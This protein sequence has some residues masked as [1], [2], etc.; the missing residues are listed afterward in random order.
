MRKILRV[1]LL[2]SVVSAFCVS[3][4]YAQSAGSLKTGKSNEGEYVIP[5]TLAYECNVAVSDSN[6]SFELEECFKRLIRDRE[7]DGDKALKAAEVWKA[8]LNESNLES[9]VVALKKKVY[10]ADYEKDVMEEF[11]NNMSGKGS[12]LSGEAGGVKATE[13]RDDTINTAQSDKH[14]AKYANE[15]L[16]SMMATMIMRRALM[17]LNNMDSTYLKKTEE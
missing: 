10:A 16:N 13:G 8:A 15:E 6:A 2:M 14:I 9:L 4:A 5:A 3:S 11:Q 17:A 7:K 1:V 12:G